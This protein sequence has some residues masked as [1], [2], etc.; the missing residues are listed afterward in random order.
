MMGDWEMLLKNLC[1]Y[2]NERKFWGMSWE[3]TEFILIG[4][5]IIDF[6]PI[7]GLHLT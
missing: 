2:E 6:L 3:I 4:F 5:Q 1:L 7:N